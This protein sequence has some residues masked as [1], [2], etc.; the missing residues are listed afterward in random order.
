[1]RAYRQKKSEGLMSFIV[2]DYSGPIVYSTHKG[3]DNLTTSKII[4]FPYKVAKPYTSIVIP[5][6]DPSL[7]IVVQDDGSV[8]SLT[9]PSPDTILSKLREDRWRET[10]DHLF[11]DADSFASNRALESA[12]EYGDIL[13]Y[14][15]L[16]ESR[17]TIDMILNVFVSLWRA[18]FQVYRK[19]KKLDVIATLDTLSD[20]WLQYR[21]GWRPLYA[22]MEALYK[23][24]NSVRVDGVKSAYGTSEV[25]ELTTDP[26]YLGDVVVHTEEAAFTYSCEFSPSEAY[27]KVGFNY[28]NTQSSRNDDW[29]AKLG[30]DLDSLLSTAW[31]LI[32][33]SFVVD[34]FLNIGSLLQVQNSSEQVDSFNYYRTHQL[35][36]QIDL[37]CTEVLTVTPGRPVD[38]KE[39]FSRYGITTVKGGR[40][41]D[42][43]ETPWDLLTHHLHNRRWKLKGKE[44][45]L[46]YDLFPGFPYITE[47]YLTYEGYPRH[48]KPP[49]Y[50]PVQ[51]SVLTD[52][53]YWN[54]RDS[55]WYLRNKSYSMDGDRKYWGHEDGTLNNVLSKIDF[56][57]ISAEQA[58][59]LI[60][61]LL[62]R[63]PGYL[64]QNLS[65]FLHRNPDW[66]HG[67][68]NS[69]KR[70][71]SAVDK[72]P[73][74]EVLSDALGIY[75]EFM[76]DHFI[77]GF[78]PES[79]QP[80]SGSLNSLDYSLPSTVTTRD[81]LP[82][83]KHVLTLDLDL[84]GAQ[85]ADLGALAL[86]FTKRFR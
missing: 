70:L 46:P 55:S 52:L 59:S 66:Y 19:A 36:G 6:V 57:S 47:F 42:G 25:R 85:Y 8:V 84:N 31:D 77:F 23:N 15:T 32:P 56:N 74:N 11:S 34:M 54:A 28:L 14:V 79:Q 80:L 39:V 76:F 43:F 86:S 72:Y 22:D 64:M 3:T 37:R 49:P 38:F 33:F 44:Y 41:Y 12:L 40:T 4:D 7:Q 24:L 60:S 83:I 10:F 29:L 48:P 27:S 30:L 20:I 82:G 45:F 61:E 5:P 73:D 62:F 67:T 78:K 68:F 75:R 58:K 13:G 69:K 35:K 81:L 63:C 26:L 65:D 2:S 17:E 18:L 1:M 16:L 50:S 71:W 21:Y 51:D 9:P 53:F